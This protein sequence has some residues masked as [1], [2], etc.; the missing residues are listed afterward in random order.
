MLHTGLYAILS[1]LSAKKNFYDF[2]WFYAEWEPWYV[3]INWI[4]N[5][6]A[7]S[8]CIRL[9]V[10]GKKNFFNSLSITSLVQSVLMLY[11]EG[12]L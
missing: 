8:R 10:I 2:L 9:T 1:H 7:D 4:K 5:R 12:N 3:N 6:F 11:K